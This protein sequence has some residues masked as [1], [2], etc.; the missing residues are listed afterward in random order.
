MDKNSSETFFLF[1][2]RYIFFVLQSVDP[3]AVSISDVQADA[4]LRFP[5]WRARPQSLLYVTGRQIQG[6]HT[7]L[8]VGV[9][10]HCWETLLALFLFFFSIS[11]AYTDKSFHC[12]LKSMRLCECS[13][14]S[15]RGGWGRGRGAGSSHQD[16]QVQHTWVALYAFWIRWGCHK[17]RSQPR[18]RSAVQ[19]N[20]GGEVHV[21]LKHINHV[22]F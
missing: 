22:P 5:N 13:D 19:S 12:L 20:P 4:R 15:P 8:C 2:T 11:I 3:P 14:C 18:L 10:D 16:P 21:L 1:Q 7:F 9:K 17:R 6:V